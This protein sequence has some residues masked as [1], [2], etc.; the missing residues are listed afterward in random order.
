[1]E[2]KEYNGWT[3]Y[4]TW[5]VNLWMSN[6][7][8]S[9]EY[10]RELAQEVYDEAEKEDRA[11]GSP[12]FTRTEVATRT[13]ADRLKDQFEEQ[14]SELTGVMGVFADLLGAALSEVDWY[15][16]AEH[17]IEDVDKEEPEP[18]NNGDEVQP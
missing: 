6:D 3:N 16:I 14:Q 5:C 18:E 17:Y 10:F 4:E 15:E 11:D 8:G 9:D 12:L 7:Q 2:R 1:M 13:L